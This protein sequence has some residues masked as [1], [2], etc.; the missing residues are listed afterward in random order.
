MVR[1]K[2]VSSEIHAFEARCLIHGFGITITGT[3]ATVLTENPRKPAGHHFD[4]KGCGSSDVDVVLSFCIGEE[5]EATQDVREACIA[6]MFFPKKQN[7]SMYKT[8]QWSNN[9]TYW[10]LKVQAWNERW[11][12]ELQFSKSI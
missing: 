2:T 6:R 4:W 8:I 12:R 10:A 3:G 11:A 9:Q 5:D 7:A 1:R